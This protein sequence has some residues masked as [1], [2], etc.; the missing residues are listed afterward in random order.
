[1]TCSPV[2]LCAVSFHR[3]EVRCIGWTLW[4]SK[5]TISTEK[6]T[7]YSLRLDLETRRVI[8][9]AGHEAVK[10]SL[11]LLRLLFSAVTSKGS[12]TEEKRRGKQQQ[13]CQYSTPT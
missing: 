11:D 1:M 4:L 3:V 5:C 12:A 2:Q 6:S 10:M 7:F 9:D 13:N 8:S